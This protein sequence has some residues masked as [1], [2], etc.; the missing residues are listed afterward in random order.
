M[1]T[2]FSIPFTFSLPDIFH[3]PLI[4]RP[5]PCVA[6]ALPLN[7]FNRGYILPVLIGRK[8]WIAA[9]TVR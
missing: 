9:T 2:P 1:V 5:D 8:R 4:A 3:N 6:A 7:V